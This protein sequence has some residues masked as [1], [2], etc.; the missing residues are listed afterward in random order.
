MGVIIDHTKLKRIREEK[1]LF[2]H[3]L[4][5]IVGYSSSRITQFELGHP[6]GVPLESLKL[7]GKALDID[8]QDLILEESEK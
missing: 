2:Q 6:G 3:E 1:G 8:Y 5:A 4:A 7:I